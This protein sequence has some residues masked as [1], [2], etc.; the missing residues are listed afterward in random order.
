MKDQMSLEK[1][2]RDRTDSTSG[3][4]PCG[5]TSNV[6]NQN[7]TFTVLLLTCYKNAINSLFLWLTK[8]LQIFSFRNENRHV[9]I[10]CTSLIIINDSYSIIV[11]TVFIV[12]KFKSKEDMTVW[13]LISKYFI[14]HKNFR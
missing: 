3:A 8:C 5:N 9:S 10:V 13:L 2:V 6:Q 4:G 11:G 1:P 12:L 7:N 14:R